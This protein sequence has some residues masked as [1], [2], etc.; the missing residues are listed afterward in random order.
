MMTCAKC[1]RT[2]SPRI[3]IYNVVDGALKQFCSF[4]CKEEYKEDYN[5]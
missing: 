2:V 3:A 1:G 4:V 5:D